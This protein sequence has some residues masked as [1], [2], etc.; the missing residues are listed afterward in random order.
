MD[1]ELTP[2]QQKVEEEVYAYLEKLVTPELEEELVAIPEG[3]GEDTHP[4]F[5]KAV[6]QLGQDG[7]LGIGWPKEFGGQNRSALEQYIFF[8]AVMGYYRVPIPLLALNTVGPTIMRHGTDEQKKR[9]LPPIL[10]GELNIAIGYTEPEAGSDLA[11][12]KTKAEKDG[13]D[14]IINGNKI[15]TS[16]AHHADYIW[17]AARTDPDVKKHKGISIFMV[18]INTPGI[19]IDPL[20]TMG[21]FKSNFTYYDDVRV[22]KDCLIGEENKGWRYINSQLA[23]ERVALVPHSRTRRAF[24]EMMTMAKE[25][26]LDGKP[27]IEEPWVRNQLAEMAVDIEVLKLFNYRVAWQLTQGVEPYAE[28]SMTKVF[29]SEL[30]QR[31]TS[32]CINMMGL[33][34]GLQPPSRLA[35]FRGKY[36]QDFL[37]MRLLTFGGG[38]NEVLRDVIAL[39]GLGMPPSR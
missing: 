14:Y 16:L 34:G 6:R 17:L 26:I 39:A 37:S 15:F 3:G 9:F 18:D 21:G 35:P 19:T 28:A 13:D 7:W 5:N 36:Q 38:A 4:H 27:I 33:V 22:P 32:A 30:L 20:Y 23:M 31:V 1:F 24:Q 25:T 2:E 10:K 29:G 12:L 8:D 11:S